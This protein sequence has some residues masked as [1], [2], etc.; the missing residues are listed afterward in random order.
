VRKGREP[1]PCSLLSPSQG[2]RR[3][4]SSPTC[5]HPGKSSLIGCPTWCTSLRSPP[6]G[7]SEE[8]HR[9]TPPPRIPP[10]L[11]QPASSPTPPGGGENRWCA[12][13][14]GGRPQW[15]EGGV[16]GTCLLVVAKGRGTRWKEGGTPAARADLVEIRGRAPQSHKIRL[17]SRSPC[18]HRCRSSSSYPSSG[19]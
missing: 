7:G 14:G 3:S 12:T 4:R 11:R 9:L 1:A 8:L 6:A 15:R 17:L 2:L 19:T 16:R 10:L 18:S 5:P 13:E